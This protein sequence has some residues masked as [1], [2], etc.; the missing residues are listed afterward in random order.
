MKSLLLQTS[1]FPIQALFIYEHYI[2]VHE[3]WGLDINDTSDD[4]EPINQVDNRKQPLLSLAVKVQL[5]RM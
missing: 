3:P 2:H 1:L 4:V 5:I